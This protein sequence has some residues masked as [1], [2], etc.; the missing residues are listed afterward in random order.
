LDRIFHITSAVEAQRATELTAYRPAAFDH[1]G[2]VH[3][4]YSHQLR[5]VANRRFAGRDGLVILEIDPARVPG[6]VIDEN[7]EGVPELFPHIYGD[8][9]MAVVA[10]HEFPRGAGGMFDLPA[11]IR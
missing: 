6:P 8:L 11:T 10:V 5:D 4:S 9:P 7:L 1:D 2:F 3:C